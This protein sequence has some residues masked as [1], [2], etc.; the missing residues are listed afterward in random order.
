MG[1]ITTPKYRLEIWSN[2]PL[3]RVA[4][5]VF[6]GPSIE[7]WQVSQRGRPTERNLEHYL[8]AQAKS[9]EH[10]GVNQHVSRALGYVPYPREARIVNQRTGQIVAKWKAA[11]FQV[12]G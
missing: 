5:M 6:A 4:E 9:F 7:S 11:T 12:F 1:R 2:A 8:F 10:G 3:R